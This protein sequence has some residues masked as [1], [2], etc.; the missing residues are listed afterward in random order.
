MPTRKIRVPGPGLG[1]IFQEISERICRDDWERR[2]TQG[3]DIVY[4]I[5]GFDAHTL[6]VNGGVSFD[7]EFPL[8]TQA[9][10]L[11]DWYTRAQLAGTQP[12]HLK[13]ARRRLADL[14]VP[15][16][17]VDRFLAGQFDELSGWH[18]K[19]P[20]YL[21]ALSNLMEAVQIARKTIAGGMDEDEDRRLARERE[22]LHLL[23][24]VKRYGAVLSRITQLDPMEFTDAQ[25]EEASRC[26]LYG[27]NRAAV[28]CAAASVETHIKSRTG[29]K[30][31]DKYSELIDT[32]FWSGLLDGSHREAASGVFETRNK[33]VHHGLNPSSDEAVTT[34]ILARSIVESLHHE[35]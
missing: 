30:R 12:D 26:Y 13:S 17:S 20:E 28:V 22:K 3:E 35:V 33:V 4:Y 11:T 8:P 31:F 1:K 9:S 25:L 29:K 10:P 21:K 2:S 7:S 23:D 18:L 32:A 16:E 34:L 5:V 15:E 19:K 14:G 24:A 27:F 6:D